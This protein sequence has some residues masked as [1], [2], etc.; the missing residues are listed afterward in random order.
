M[1]HI[2]FLIYCVGTTVHRTFY[3]LHVSTSFLS[4][5]FSS[6]LLL[7]LVQKLLLFELLLLDVEEDAEPCLPLPFLTAT[8]REVMS[9]TV[10]MV[11]M[12]RYGAESSRANCFDVSM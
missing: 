12:L 10:T 8:M 3:S 11:A 4:R 6:Y 1:H 7:V 5:D 9:H 2:T